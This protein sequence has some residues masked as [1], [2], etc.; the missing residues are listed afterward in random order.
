MEEIVIFDTPSY[1]NFFIFKI[2]SSFLA[3]FVE[4]VAWTSLNLCRNER[5][6][7]A[8]KHDRGDHRLG[9]QRRGTAADA[10]QLQPGAELPGLPAGDRLGAGQRPAGGVHAPGLQQ[11][12]QRPGPAQ[13]PA[14]Q[15]P[16]AQP[17]PG[18][19]GRRPGV[20][21]GAGV[22]L[23]HG[24]GRGA[25]LPGQGGQRRPGGPGQ[26]LALPQGRL[27]RT[28][29]KVSAALWGLG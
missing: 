6:R 26:S 21:G 25:G 4:N 20:G 16:L 8:E 24:R 1:L 29:R 2:S 10:A 18:G 5:C 13:L 17:L 11:L 23:R 14:V 22:D 3:D 7:C 12:H 19:R 15:G 28:H 9:V 27:C